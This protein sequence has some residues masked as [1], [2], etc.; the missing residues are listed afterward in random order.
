VW[1]RVVIMR[2]SDAVGSAWGSQIVLASGRSGDGALVLARDSAEPSIAMDSAGYLHVVWVSASAAG[3]GSTLNLVRYTKTTV[4]WPTESELASGLNWQS[5]TSVDDTNPGYMPTVS[6]DWN[7]YPHIAWSQSKSITVSEAAA[8][9]YRSNTGTNTVN[10]PKSRTWDG[11][12]WS[13][14]ETEE[15]TAGSPLRNVRMAYSPIA[16]DERIFVTVSDDGWL[17]AYVCTPTCTVT[18]NLGQV[19][20]SAPGSADYRFAIAYEQLS[21][22]A[23]LVYGVLSTDTTHDIAYREYTGSWGPEQYLDNTNNAT[24]LQYIQIELAPKA[25]SDQVGLMAGTTNYVV[26]AWIWS[27]TAFGSFAEVTPT[28]FASSL[29]D[30]MAIAWETN[31]GHLLAV[32]AAAPLGE[33][34]VYREFTTSW[35]SSSTYPC[36]T[37][38]KNDY[39]LSLR[40]NP[41]PTTDEMILLIGQA[42]SAVSTCYWSGS[43]WSNFVTHDAASD[44]WTTRSEDFAWE[45]TGSK[46][47]LVWGTNNGQITYRTFTAPNTW[48]TI[49]NV[50]MGTT[51]HYWVTLRSN[52]S[53]QPGRPKVLGAVLDLNDD[54]GAITWDGSAFTVVGA[55]SFTADT[56]SHTYENFDLEYRPARGDGSVYYKNEASGTW[57]ATVSWDGAYT[58]HSVD[59]S[60]KND[61]VSLA[62]YYDAGTNEIQYTVCKTLNASLCDASSEF[63]R[64]NGAAGIDSVASN[65]L[66]GGYPTLATTWDSNADL[67]VGYTTAAGAVYARFLDYPSGGWQAAEQIDSTGG[68]TYGRL[69]IVN[70]ATPQL[71]YKQRLSGVWDSSRTAVDTSS[72]WPVVAVRAPNDATYG[73]L[74]GALYWK[75]T[76]TGTYFF[77]IPEFQ[78]IVVPILTILFL[79]LVRRRA[80]RRTDYQRAN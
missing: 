56:G 63:T 6:T 12:S 21:G 76:T 40:P 45:S 20:S 43:G 17:D 73:T 67:W 70:I 38:G 58:G 19:W 22:R 53:P 13:A 44:S 80:R 37:S 14:P 3:D 28:G 54:L 48:G 36:G 31:S 39:W 4:A 25:A 18:N 57:R 55:N 74:L 23:L 46:G 16:N 11:T 72:E 9:E 42:L 50:T 79:G 49:T 78:L 59:V 2:S 62:R 27:G 61:F 34:I 75:T 71:Y 32:T 41:V 52:P 35:S 24:D 77:R 66:S 30:R 47:L 1:D 15:S 60:P 26:T 69:S 68:T 8:I 7:G 65:V 33:T 5:A 64:W 51:L 29:G 10:S